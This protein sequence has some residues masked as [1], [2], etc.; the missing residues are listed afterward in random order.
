MEKLFLCILPNLIYFIFHNL[1]K[2]I[3]SHNVYASML[4][5]IILIKSL[6]ITIILLPPLLSCMGFNHGHQNSYQFFMVKYIKKKQKYIGAMVK[7][8]ITIPCQNVLVSFKIILI[9]QRKFQCQGHLH[10]FHPMDC[11]III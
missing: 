2:H 6:I 1:N 8:I 7:Y 5:M 3:F 11:Y 4:K 9:R 10:I